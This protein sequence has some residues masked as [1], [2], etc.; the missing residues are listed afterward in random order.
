M[1]DRSGRKLRPRQ[2][3]PARNIRPEQSPCS[4]PRASMPLM[5]NSALA[6][7]RSLL[8]SS[9]LRCRPWVDL[10][11]CLPEIRDRVAVSLESGQAALQ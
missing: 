10:R 3:D 2:F 1:T 4:G 5:R 8:K 6:K 11:A 9:L 7:S